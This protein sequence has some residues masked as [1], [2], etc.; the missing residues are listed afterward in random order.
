[1]G[2]CKSFLTK[3]FAIFVVFLAIAFLPGL[4]PEMEF[5]PYTPSEPLDFTGPLAPNDKLNGAE[6]IFEG[7]IQNPECLAVANGTVYTSSRGGDIVKLVG[8]KLVPVANIGHKCEGYWEEKK[9]GRTLGMTFD[10]KGFLYVVDAYYGI[11]KINVNTGKVGHLIK[12]DQP[13][14]GKTVKIANSVAV[15]KDGTVYWTASSCDTS[16]DDAVLTMLGDATG[17][18]FK[19]D[20]ASKTNTLLLDK[21]HFANGLA[22]SQNEDFVVV[23]ETVRTRLVRYWLKGPKQGSSEIFFDSLPGIPDNIKVNKEG[24]FDVTVPLQRTKTYPLLSDL[25]APYPLIRRF[26]ARVFYL[27]E[28][29]FT[30]IQDNYPNFYSGIITHLI[31]SFDPLLPLFPK[32]VLVL[33]FDQNGKLLSSLRST[34]DKVTLISDI[35]LAGNYYYLGSPFNNYLGRVK[36]DKIKAD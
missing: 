18:L 21:V 27:M 36:I 10:T 5:T 9:C 4:P 2:F 29:P 23:A 14:S 34:D 6:R 3:L 19:F 16:F 22:L 31:G 26:L 12:I 28:V 13:I 32:E 15:G 35:I 24:I 11:Y 7:K 30:L 1:M 33:Q 17:R 20:P 25:I 8:D